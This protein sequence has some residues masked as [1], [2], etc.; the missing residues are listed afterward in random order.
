MS[1]HTTLLCS[2]HQA[3]CQTEITYRKTCLLTHKLFNKGASLLKNDWAFSHLVSWVDDATD[4]H[5]LGTHRAWMSNVHMVPLK[6]K[7]FSF[8][9]E[10]K[11]LIK[12][13][14]SWLR[15]WK[16]SKTCGLMYKSD[17]FVLFWIIVRHLEAVAF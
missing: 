3:Q 1:G 11:Y 15:I 16:M 6:K 14:K 8:S 4:E 9:T 7:Y 13:N 12:T 17:I 5:H 10:A 2:L